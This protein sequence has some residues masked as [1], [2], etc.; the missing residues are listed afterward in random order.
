M[1]RRDGPCLSYQ[2]HS[3]PREV[4]LPGESGATF[5]GLHHY[6]SESVHGTARTW[7][8]S[9]V[10]TAAHHAISMP[11]AECT[12]ECI[13]C[14]GWTIFPIRARRE[15][16]MDG[17]TVERALRSGEEKKAP[18][19]FLRQHPGPQGRTDKEHPGSGETLGKHPGWTAPPTLSPPF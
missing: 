11:M 13:T 10:I 19:P 17:A 2:G 8:W 6:L 15:Q 5:F 4:I 14:W 12:R 18:G 9:L 16:G 1:Q 7:Y 3:E